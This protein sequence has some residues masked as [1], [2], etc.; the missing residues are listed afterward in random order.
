MRKLK[1]VMAIIALSA[2]AVSCVSTSSGGKT[3]RPI[4]GIHPAKVG[5]SLVSFTIDPNVPYSDFE[6]LIL[7]TKSDID[8]VYPTGKLSQADVEKWEKD[9]GAIRLAINTGNGSNTYASFSLPP[10][11]RQFAFLSYRSEISGSV[12]REFWNVYKADIEVGMSG[13]RYYVLSDSGARQVSERVSAL[14]EY[15][16]R[17]GTQIGRNAQTILAHPQDGFISYDMI[18]PGPKTTKAN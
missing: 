17:Y 13:H 18:P 11:T 14:F 1:S 3:A 15:A 2:I 8:A 16:E 12:K 10:G 5:E 7:S 9:S 4:G 6:V